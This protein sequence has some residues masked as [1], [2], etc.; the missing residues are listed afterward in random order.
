MLEHI[1]F[2]A[3]MAVDAAI[4]NVPVSFFILFVKYSASYNYSV[5]F[6]WRQ[7]EQNTGDGKHLRLVAKIKFLLMISGPYR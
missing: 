4:P 5:G 1:I 2:A 6:K 7:R 3:K